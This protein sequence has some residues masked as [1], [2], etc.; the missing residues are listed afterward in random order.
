MAESD[1]EGLGFVVDQI[2]A[3]MVEFTPQEV[4]ASFTEE[5]FWVQ[6]AIPTQTS[7]EVVDH[8]GTGTGDNA[9][10]VC[11]PTTALGQAIKACQV[12]HMTE[13]YAGAL[14]S[15]I[16]GRKQPFKGSNELDAAAERIE[17]K[18]QGD[19]G[20]PT[21]RKL[22]KAQR[23]GILRDTTA[24]TVGRALRLL[25]LP[26]AKVTPPVPPSSPKTSG[27]KRKSKAVMDENG[28][29]LDIID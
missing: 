21:L 15:E 16:L 18:I 10:Y 17:A 8:E 19:G 2:E 12:D 14:F 29:L 20:S 28:E 26:K 3:M 25:T 24:N 1:E 6:P 5:G 4:Q 11:E 9:K 13:E 23:T 7:G 27:S 22:A